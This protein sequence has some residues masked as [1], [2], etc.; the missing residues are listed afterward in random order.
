MD[1]GFS[2]HYA[3]V[4]SICTENHSSRPQ[5]VRKRVFKEEG[6]KELQ[7][8]LN[9]ETWQEMFLESEVNAKF[10]T[11]M[12]TFLYYFDTVF[13]LKVVQWREPQRKSWVMEVIKTSSRHM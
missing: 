13:P 1:L 7:Y 12:D 11:F 4:L 6:I 8:V 5:R 9:K 3:Q 2:N 10:N